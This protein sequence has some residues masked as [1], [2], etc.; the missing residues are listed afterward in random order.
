MG[1][2]A[3]RSFSFKK[4]SDFTPVFDDS[5]RLGNR[6]YRAWFLKILLKNGKLNSPSC[7]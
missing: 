4:L 2:L 7:Y 6:T 3:N 1:L 5:V